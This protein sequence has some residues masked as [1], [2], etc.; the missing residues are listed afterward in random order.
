[1][2]DGWR[3]NGGEEKLERRGE[4]EGREKERKGRQRGDSRKCFVSDG[5]RYKV[6]PGLYLFFIINFH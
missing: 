6:M 1:M 3:K 4:E 2:T 5:D